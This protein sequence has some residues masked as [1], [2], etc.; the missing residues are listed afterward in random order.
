MGGTDIYE[1][2]FLGCSD[3]G[4]ARGQIRDGLRRSSTPYYE[5]VQTM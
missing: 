5:M 2:D 3:G 4:D 1:C